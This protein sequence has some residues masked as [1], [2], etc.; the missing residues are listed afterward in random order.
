MD[1]NGI[2]SS[3][4]V[5]FARSISTWGSWVICIRLH[6]CILYRAWAPASVKSVP[7]VG[8]Q[9]RIYRPVWNRDALA[10]NLSTIV[11]L[12]S[13]FPL[14]LGDL[15]ALDSKSWSI[16]QG[17]AGILVASAVDRTPVAILVGFLKKSAKDVDPVIFVPS[18]IPSRRES[19][20]VLRAAVAASSAKVVVPPSVTGEECSL[21]GPVGSLVFLVV[22]GL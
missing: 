6:E 22:M 16:C 17:T 21:L 12:Q 4:L 18:T 9:A 5:S 3:T 8:I 19:T 2:L 7:H 10:C 20:P 13:K 15:L 11:A 1:M 14:N